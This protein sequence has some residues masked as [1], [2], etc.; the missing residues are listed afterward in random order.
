M[1]NIYSKK[2]ETLANKENPFLI[3]YLLAGYKNTDEL[4]EVLKQLPADALDVLELGFPSRNPYSD[5]E[6]ISTAH[7]MVDKDVACSIEYWQKVK[8][9]YKKPI[10]VM[11]YREDFI[12]S[13]I[14][15][16]FAK[17]QLID[18]IVIPDT[19]TRKE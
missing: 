11:A 9:L 2:N 15:K 10:W 17:N 19:T 14:Y 18:A 16:E 13:G 12:E 5:G 6:V 7:S 1:I 3:G 8:D 4:L